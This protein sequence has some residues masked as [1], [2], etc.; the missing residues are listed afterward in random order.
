MQ[1]VKGETKQLRKECRDGQK[2][3]D[4]YDEALEELR[5][6]ESKYAKLRSERKELKGILKR[7]RAVEKGLKEILRENE[8]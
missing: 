3:V 1:V 8:L 5:K 7:H 6:E 2:V 4:E